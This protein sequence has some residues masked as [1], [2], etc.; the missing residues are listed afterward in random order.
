MPGHFVFSRLYTMGKEG[1]IVHINDLIAAKQEINDKLGTLEES[2]MGR[3]AEVSK[4]ANENFQSVADRSA[5]NADDLEALREESR[6]YTEECCE[7]L[8]E[9]LNLVL[10]GVRESLTSDAETQ[11][12][13]ATARA[14]TLAADVEE[15][16]LKNEGLEDRI[17]STKSELTREFQRD[18]TSGLA[19]HASEQE[20]SI[21]QLQSSL[22]AFK[23]SIHQQAAEEHRAREKKVQESL[24]ESLRKMSSEQIKE[25]AG[26][27]MDKIQQHLVRHDA[28]LS[29]C[30]NSLKGEVGC[31][32]AKLDRE[33]E[34][35]S[36]DTERR[37]S[38]AESERVDIKEAVSAAASASTRSIQWV[39]PDVLRD[40]TGTCQSWF[41]PRF[42]AAGEAG[43][44]LEL[45]VRALGI[46]NATEI[47]RISSSTD[48]IGVG[49]ARR[50][51]P[52]D[53]PTAQK[54]LTTAT[55]MDVL[56]GQKAQMVLKEADTD[57]KPLKPAYEAKLIL[58][59]GSSS[60]Q[61]EGATTLVF[62]LSLSGMSGPSQE[63]RFD[64]WSPCPSGRTW[65]LDDRF[66]R[67]DG[68]VR[69]V[70]DFLAAI[71]ALELHKEG[72]TLTSS[73]EVSP[74]GYRAPAP[75]WVQPLT[76]D[77]GER[78]P[79][80]PQHLPELAIQRAGTLCVH[81]Q[82]DNRMDDRMRSCMVRRIE[83]R[84]EQGSTLKAQF[85][86]GECIYSTCFSA[87]GMDGLQLIFYPMGCASAPSGYS[88]FFLH[89]PESMPR[90]W[91]HVGK[92]RIE[93]L[94][95][96]L[97]PGWVGRVKFWHCEKFA[98]AETD[99]V[100]LA[101]EVQEAPS[102]VLQVHASNDPRRY[103]RKSL[104]GGVD[105]RPP[106]QGRPSSRSSS[107]A[108]RRPV[109]PATESTLVKG[110]QTT[111]WMTQAYVD[112]AQGI[113]ANARVT[114]PRGQSSE[115]TMMPPLTP[116]PPPSHHPMHNSMPPIYA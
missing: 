68:S 41:S 84:L 94:H 111:H 92:H 28:Q 19:A 69:V 34:R 73:P 25:Q 7:A 95:E 12:A 2:L 87:A 10:E 105:V 81:H 83:W 9:E 14:D 48:P 4:K 49:G 33:F 30:E 88:S 66:M 44:Q 80:S 53:T 56:S 26:E 23:T 72:L 31:G 8:K 46:E 11:A 1:S 54:V 76:L 100:Y 15:L 3:A 32:I 98:D 42:S 97:Q 71:G 104:V 57:Q 13:T 27:V 106:S 38:L 86:R 35:L 39:I 70:A 16:K 89:C 5:K 29:F 85:P 99:L 64:R 79:E 77:F 47:P 59:A 52:N 24:V 82:I 96:E 63:N 93:A 58:W 102:E 116:S 36:Q 113:N 60:R 109:P 40:L 65:R 17:R 50:P 22:Q 112:S 6:K 114:T 21:N 108:R 115:R 91:L 45:Q 20:R 62:R 55:E 107:K 37:L 103:M 43:L 67:E 101:V 18:L 74:G 110:A 61:G 78:A 90:A 75:A 51:E